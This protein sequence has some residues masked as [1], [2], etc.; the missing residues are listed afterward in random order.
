MIQL[1]Q[2]NRPEVAFDLS[3]SSRYGSVGLQYGQKDGWIRGD[4]ESR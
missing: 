4:D 2:Q 3:A 1:K